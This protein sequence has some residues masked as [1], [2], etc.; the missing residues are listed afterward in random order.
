MII[1]FIQ[2]YAFCSAIFAGLL[3][4]RLMLP[5]DAPWW[6]EYATVLGVSGAVYLLLYR[7]GVTG[8]RPH[9]R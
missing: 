1:R 6:L 8:N 2:R 3:S 4:Y 7:D 5:D 9:R